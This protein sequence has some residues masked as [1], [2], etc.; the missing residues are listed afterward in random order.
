M[1]VRSEGPAAGVTAHVAAR[2]APRAVMVLLQSMPPS[3]REGEVAIL[4]PT[5]NI[6][7]HQQS[8][9][10]LAA[11]GTRRRPAWKEWLAPSVPA[12]AWREHAGDLLLVPEDY[13]RAGRSA[14]VR[15]L[16]RDQER[17]NSAV[18]VP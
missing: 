4:G 8:G 13:A 2:V 7:A 5:G 17:C 16:L 6:G 18:P 10:N 11:I 12:R 1:L 14:A 9:A 3:R 15:R